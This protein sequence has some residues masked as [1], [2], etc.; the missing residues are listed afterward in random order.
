M[1]K[2]YTS[3]SV[4]D[5][6]I[7]R[8]VK[9]Y[10]EG[11]RLTYSFSGGK[12]SGVLA[13]LGIIAADIAG[14]LPIEVVMR[15][16][17]IAYPGT[18]EYAERLA[19]RPEVKFHWYSFR[20][21][22]VNIFNREEPFF[23]VFDPYLD[24]SDW[25]RE[26]PYDLVKWD[27]KSD[28]DLYGLVNLERFPN[29]EGA[30]LCSCVG[31][32]A[33]ESMTRH[34]AI[35]SAHGPRSNATPDKGKNMIKLY[36]LYD[37]KTEDI[38]KAILDNHWDY[39]EAY[40]VMSKMGISPRKQRLGLI[41]MSLNGIPSLQFA[42][43]AW[44]QWF[45]KVCQ[46]LPGV[47]TV[48]NF[49]VRA[50]MPVKRSGETWE[51][52]YQRVCIDTAPGWIRERALYARERILRNHARHSVIP[53]GEIGNCGVCNLSWKKFTESMYTGDPFRIRLNFLLSIEPIHWRPEDKRAWNHKL[54]AKLKKEEK[55]EL[56]RAS[57]T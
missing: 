39:N 29:P 19:R 34:L 21:G 6:S 54:M 33:E 37:W 42:A 3:E 32:R 35:Q 17:E 7:R 57:V 56:A 8:L 30:K 26:P 43:K 14:K 41:A 55:A 46:R 49:G 28:P 18:F 48:A 10:N 45:D 31:I 16:D 22:Q 4:F 13:E 1:A 5:A 24:P 53:L 27:T 47:H 50:L 52:C 23:W 20:Q 12:D 36:P 11:H 2:Q 44:P 25:V 9:A 51:E 40:N 15:D 38:W